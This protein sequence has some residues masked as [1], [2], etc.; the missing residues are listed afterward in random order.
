M[1]ERIKSNHVTAMQKTEI[2]LVSIEELTDEELKTVHGAMS[3]REWFG[4]ERG[5]NVSP[6][7]PHKV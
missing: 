3:D 1:N 2:E 6:T 4:W 7:T 5:F